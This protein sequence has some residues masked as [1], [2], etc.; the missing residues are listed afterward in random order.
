MNASELE[1][2]RDSSLHVTEYHESALTQWAPLYMWSKN[3]VAKSEAKRG[4][5]CQ[6]PLA[7]QLVS[8]N[9]VFLYFDITKNIMIL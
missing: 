2:S 4:G 9:L 6:F 3:L 1:I 7:S 5:N 8:R